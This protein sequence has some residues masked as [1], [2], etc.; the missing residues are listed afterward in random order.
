MRQR[1]LVGYRDGLAR[2]V[3]VLARLKKY[4]AAWEALRRDTVG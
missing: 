4:R 2:Q 1:Q 3:A